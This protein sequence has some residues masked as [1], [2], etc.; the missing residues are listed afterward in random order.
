M[1]FMA[2]ENNETNSNPPTDIYAEH[3]Q[4]NKKP[5][6]LTNALGKIALVGAA[7]GVV[8]AG[9]R[10]RQE[11]NPT[12]IIDDTVNISKSI[13]DKVNP[14]AESI[15]IQQGTVGNE[16]ISSEKADLSK[17]T[18][19]SDNFINELL[20]QPA[21]LMM[22]LKEQGKEGVKV[23][24]HNPIL[25]EDELFTF[26]WEEGQ[27][28]KRLTLS[29]KTDGELETFEIDREKGTVL[30]TTKDL[31]KENDHVESSDASTD[32]VS[33]LTDK[34]KTGHETWLKSQRITSSTESIP[35][36]LNPT[37]PE[38]TPTPI[39]YN[40]RPDPFNRGIQEAN[41]QLATE[42]QKT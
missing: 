10:A 17:L 41:T 6:K 35:P 36:T 27:K 29:I 37:K 1:K 4:I 8:G 28:D 33:T 32:I 19:V 26:I 7:I 16:A 42:E 24:I 13:A 30:K 34:V 31:N 5:N 15:S 12:Q 11:N 2:S 40:P 14:Q 21:A 23:N 39:P 3:R 25:K 18:E 38:P 20:K 9:A 22:G